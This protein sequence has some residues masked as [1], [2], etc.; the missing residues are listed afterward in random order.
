MPPI[1]NA[2]GQTRFGV[3][4]AASGAPV[5]VSMVSDGMILHLD[6]GNPS[7]YS[8]TGTTWT[9]LSGSNN[10]AT[11]YNSPV[12]SSDSQGSLVF[13][14]TSNYAAVSDVPFRFGN[15][16]TVSIWFYWDGV[17]KTN[18]NMIAKRNGAPVYN[19]YSMG[20]NGGDV[21]NGGTG[22]TFFFFC[23]QENSAGYT[24]DT[25]LRYVLPA[26][27]G[28]YNITGT[29]D[30]TS[31]RLYVNGA[32]V[33]QS[34][35]NLTGFTYNVPGRALLIGNTWNDAA[36]GVL[37]GYS[38]GIYAAAVYNR[39]LTQ[40]E[41]VQN[42]DSKKSRFGFAAS[43]SDANA[44][45][46]AAAIGSP[47]IYSAVDALVSDLKAA[48]IWTKM[49]VLYPFVGGVS[50][51]HK[52]N[53]KDPRDL[54]AAYRLVFSGGWTHASTGAKPNGINGY[55]DSRF[56]ANLM[57]PGNAHMSFYNRTSSLAPGYLPVIQ[58]NSGWNAPKTVSM[59]V[60]NTNN[61]GVV[62]VYFAGVGSTSTSVKSTA[63]TSFT[64]GTTVALNSQ[65]I[66][67][68][69]IIQGSSTT[70]ATNTFS[71]SN[72][73]IGAHDGS[74]N[75]TNSQ[76]TAF[77]SF[78]DGL[79][80]AE[81]RSFNA[82]VKKFQIAL[83]RHVGS[84]IVSDADAQAF[85]DAA[86]VTSSSQAS[87]VN[88][89]VTDL[90][91]ASIWTKMKVLYPFVGGTAYS[92][93]W[94]LKDPRDVDAAYR[95]VFSGGWAHSSN[96]ALPNGTT[97]Y[98]N[99]YFNPSTNLSIDNTHMSYYSRTNNARDSYDMGLTTTTTS[100]LRS[101]HAALKWSDSSTYWSMGFQSSTTSSSEV[102][103]TLS[104]TG[105]NFLFNKTS[106][107]STSLF[108]N[109]TK[110][111]ASVTNR[112]LPSGNF[113]LG[114]RN[115]NGGVD[116]FT[117][118]QTAFV[119]IGEGLTDAEAAAFYA[120]VQ[121]YQASLGR[122]VVSDADAQAFI[123][124]AAITDSA[125]RDAINTL[126]TDLKSASIWTKMK[127]IYP[128]VGGTA[129]SHKFN[130]K[131]PRDLDAA[132][133]L[134]FSGGW[135]HA[136]TGAKPNG[137][138]GY[139][140]TKLVPSSNLSVNSTHQSFYFRTNKSISFNT[141][142]GAYTNFGSNNFLLYPYSFN[143]GWISDICDNSASRIVS[144]AGN[145]TGYIIATRASSSSHKMFRNNSLIASTSNATTGTHPSINYYIGAGN[146]NG[147]PGDYDS[148]EI[149]LSSIG[150]GLTDAEAA[151]FYTAVQKYQT[152]LGRQV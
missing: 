141:V 140:D 58:D 37:S 111:T 85:L 128:F 106:S 31:Q 135:T 56:P 11:L 35:L 139:A 64:V 152:S 20:I 39:P 80:D 63:W 127:A 8:G 28:Y 132:Y 67:N 74:L 120:A 71:T 94:N 131:D 104:S 34:S 47:S 32:L 144:N 105:A 50:F 149:A 19:S 126:V 83:D 96:G 49:K 12:Y 27:P 68:E 102:S 66:Y 51:G 82:A 89:L 73:V 90:K 57:S 7:S 114:A 40:A 16:F 65:K 75:Y 142:H 4:K 41:V 25:V 124:A 123:D 22:K 137:T 84:P 119:S 10:N 98:A 118:R 133:R 24:T 33:D 100:P 113:Y 13:N 55:A 59:V 151:A 95:L 43:D 101:M 9:D 150:E 54:D 92:H 97:G 62:S 6:A 46:S 109:N 78:G 148:N 17:D 44:F 121:K 15:R 145:S 143:I 26:S 91:S 81:V 115:L 53:L 129:T 86:Q 42:F 146:K 93:K 21:Y 2:L 122:Q 116:A 99:T 18:A 76:E 72:L 136:S 30:A 70:S 45:L 14:G 77:V 29:M 110:Y 61:G 23:R 138:T 60:G 103:A 125:Q 69:G 130:L 134:V 52:F 112:S 38:K 87:A 79:T 3:R 108:A 117:N 88:T 1:T 48:S 36:S 147:S 107:T 5:S